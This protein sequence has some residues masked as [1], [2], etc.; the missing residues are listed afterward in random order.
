MLQIMGVAPTGSIFFGG[1]DLKVLTKDTPD[2][3]YTYVVHWP[4]FL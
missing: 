4:R 1:G 3:Y 2:G